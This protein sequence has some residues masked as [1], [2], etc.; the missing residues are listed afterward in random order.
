MV[1][2]RLSSLQQQLPLTV[3]YSQ[4][5]HFKLPGVEMELDEVCFQK[6]KP[7]SVQHQP[8]GAHALVSGSAVRSITSITRSN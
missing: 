8:G 3:E 6:Y 2:D 4:L 7:D 5:G 1:T